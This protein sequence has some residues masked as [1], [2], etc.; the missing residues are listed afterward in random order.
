MPFDRGY[1]ELGRWFETF[2]DREGRKGLTRGCVTHVDFGAQ[3]TGAKRPAFGLGGPPPWRPASSSAAQGSMPAAACPA[4][5]PPGLEA[6][7]RLSGLSIGHIITP[8]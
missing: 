7:A 2:P 5:R 1:R 6:R 3:R 8:E 4:I